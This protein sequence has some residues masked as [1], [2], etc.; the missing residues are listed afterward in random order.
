MRAVRGRADTRWAPSRFNFAIF[1]LA[2]LVVASRAVVEHRRG[3]V[4]VIDR[5]QNAAESYAVSI[6]VVASLTAYAASLLAAP[7]GW[8]AAAIVALPA[9]LVLCQA[10][11][12]AG[13]LFVLPAIRHDHTRLNSVLLM[14]S[15]VAVSAWIASTTLWSRYVGML[16]IAI[17]ALNAIAAVPARLL[18]ARMAAADRARGVT[19]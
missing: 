6:W 16:F 8:I 13:G 1:R 17:V 12:V 9:V 4:L 2:A 19:D 3:E 14:T 5:N 7:L 15:L 18:R 11:I 10:A